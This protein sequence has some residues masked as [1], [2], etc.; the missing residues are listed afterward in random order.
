M[1]RR[2]PSYS[3]GISVLLWLPH[4]SMAVEAASC[5]EQFPQQADLRLTCY[6]DKPATAPR[7]PSYTTEHIERSY[8][9]RAWNL[10]DENNLDDSQLG[11]LQPY[12]QNYLLLRDTNKP[13][14]QPSSSIV[15]RNAVLSSD[16]DHSEAKFLISVKAD[17]GTQRG[18]NLLGLK[19]VR[20]WGAYTQQSHWQVLNT[21]NS[22][23]FRET[24]YTPELIATL[25][26]NQATGLKL[27][28]LGL[29]HQSN[30]RNLPE[31]RSWNRL[32]ALGG[33]EWN[34]RTSLMTRAWWR[35][36]ESIAND[37]NP[38]IRDY[39]GIGDML[40]R[41]E[42]GNRSQAVSLLL[43]NNLQRSKNRGFAQLDWALPFN[44]GDSARLHLQISTGFGESLIDYN[45][46]QTT[47]GLG[48]S[49]RE[50]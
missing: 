45:H 22:S 21:R 15:G 29:E 1:P 46:P 27:I 25:G 37:D 14:S 34:N 43:R 26:T 23:P 17:I 48:V 44:A 36:P 2:R 13:N 47:L 30:G 33:W 42:T 9:T 16:L 39:Y 28:N 19:T 12:R 5:L 6:D 4:V 41:W 50:W 32:Y 8:L 35:I 38:D 18:I 40:V 24:N 31:S 10:D 20:L 3:L 49:F 7:A 11:S